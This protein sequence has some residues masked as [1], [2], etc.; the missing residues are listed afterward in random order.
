MTN[1]VEKK[2][3]IHT[4]MWLSWEEVKKKH[5]DKWVLLGGKNTKQ[6]ENN[7]L[8]ILGVAD[9]FDEINE[10]DNANHSSFLETK[11]YAMFTLRTTKIIEKTGKLVFP[12]YTAVILK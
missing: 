5:P 3:A 1:Q 2:V 12:I 10:F 4:P 6:L 7:E 9:S 11:Q 8:D